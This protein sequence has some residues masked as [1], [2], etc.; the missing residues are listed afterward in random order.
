MGE[1]GMERRREEQ[2]ERR[3][4]EHWKWQAIHPCTCKISEFCGGSNTT[5]Q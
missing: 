1:E 2:K 4:K 3:E 5:L